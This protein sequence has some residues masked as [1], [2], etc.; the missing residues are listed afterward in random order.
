[1]KTTI[2]P[3][4]CSRRFITLS[5]WTIVLAVAFVLPGCSGYDDYISR[6]VILDASNRPPI[7][8]GPTPQKYRDQQS[9]S[10]QQR[11]NDYRFNQ[12]APSRT[13]QDR[14]GESSYER[15]S[16]Y[17]D[18]NRPDL[19]QMNYAR[20]ENERFMPARPD[21]YPQSQRPLRQE[22]YRAGP[23]N[24]YQPANRM[25]TQ[26]PYQRTTPNYERT[27]P[28]VRPYETSAIAQNDYR[29]LPAQPSGAAYSQTVRSSNL[30]VPDPVVTGVSV[31][32]VHSASPAA[33]GSSMQPENQ[34][35]PTDS[36]TPPTANSMPPTANFSVPGR[37]DTIAGTQPRAAQTRYEVPAGAHG[38]AN[39]IAELEKKAVTRPDD[40]NLA[41]A[42]RYLYLIDG[43]T[44]RA[45]QVMPLTADIANA[46][47]KNLDDLRVQVADRADLQIPTLKIC[48]N[49]QGFGEY[50]ELALSSLSSGK[51]RN[52][53]VYCELKNVKTERNKED[54]HLAR[55]H[56]TISLYDANYQLVTQ[57]SSDV[58]DTPSYNPRQDFY[59]QGGLKVPE[60]SPGRYQLTITIEDKI[61]HKIARPK[62]IY[63]EVKQTYQNWQ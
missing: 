40:I 15:P 11:A 37:P 19:R 18:V 3:S 34:F 7:A 47:L 59:L 48:E 5:L 43:Q 60:L 31:S 8:T 61:A 55:L 32:E 14:Q 57:L 12:P 9:S 28:A 36:T 33:T 41:L 6:P 1:M 4:V 45:Q 17:R 56:A 29:N 49:V 23:I 16:Q 44:D 35:R 21:N 2:N 58:P 50:T 38:I 24:N 10:N 63:F 22:P 54:K 13:Y 46:M 39:T 53:V 30:L 52:I 42:L 26:P 62:H 27:I 20:N 25:V 51:S